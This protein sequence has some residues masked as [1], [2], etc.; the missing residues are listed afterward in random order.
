MSSI[1]FLCLAVLLASYSNLIMKARAAK[2]GALAAGRVASYLISM[3]IDPL[4]WTAVAAFALAALLWLLVIRSL[5]LG[6]ALPIMALT[7]VFTPL[8]ASIVLHEP[9]PP[10]RVAGLVLIVAG[11]IL[12]GKTA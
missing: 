10:L 6:F 8:G 5:D 1:L 7:L 3:A 12:V 9:L 2:L 4:V 11:V